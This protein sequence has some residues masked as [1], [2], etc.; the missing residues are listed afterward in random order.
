MNVQETDHIEIK[1]RILTSKRLISYFPAYFASKLYTANQIIFENKMLSVKIIKSTNCTKK[2]RYHNMLEFR[3][4]LQ[5]KVQS[6][7]QIFFSCNSVWVYWEPS[8]NNSESSSL[9]APIFI[10]YSFFSNSPFDVF[11]FL[12]WRKPKFFFSEVFGLFV[13]KGEYFLIHPKK[14]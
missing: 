11:P 6:C 12:I 7:F 1:K 3:D 4:F 9:K 5:A 8:N 14:K 13:V 2:H 10:I